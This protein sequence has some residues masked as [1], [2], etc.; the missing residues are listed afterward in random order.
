MN[1]NFN[2]MLWL[3]AVAFFTLLGLMIS[4]IYVTHEAVNAGL[5]QCMVAISAD[6]VEPLWQKECN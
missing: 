2:F 6:D 4:E 5:Q 1:F 3:T